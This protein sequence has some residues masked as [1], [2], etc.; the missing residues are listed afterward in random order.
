MET[1]RVVTD[2][3]ALDVG[4]IHRFLSEQSPW[5][6]GIPYDVVERALSNSLCFGGFLGN[7]QVAFARVISDY[8]TFANLVD[9]FVVP[10]RRGKGHSKALMTAVLAHPQLQGLR[11]FTLVTKNAH[12]LY[13]HFGFAAPLHPHTLMERYLPDIY[14]GSA[15]STS[16][17]RGTCA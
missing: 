10:A 8:A 9:V 15:W 3:D 14:A 1:L 12:G 2:W 6:A 11:R 7:E 16:E 5:A 17:Q 13:A 4:L